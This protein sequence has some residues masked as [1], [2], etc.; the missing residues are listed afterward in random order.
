[1]E[2]S[3][4]PR[5]EYI[6]LRMRMTAGIDPADY[7]ACFGRPFT[8]LAAVLARYAPHGLTAFRDGRWRLS[9][10]GMFVSN[11]ILEE[12]L[13]ADEKAER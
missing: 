11:T 12:L 2:E 4:D 7:E 9:P 13:E 5:E 10:R 1:M 6:I 3:P 8:P